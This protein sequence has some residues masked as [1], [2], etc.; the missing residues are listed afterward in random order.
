M[1]RLHG[2]PSIT[3]IHHN[4]LCYDLGVSTKKKEKKVN[5]SALGGSLPRQSC[6]YFELIQGGCNQDSFLRFRGAFQ[7]VTYNN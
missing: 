7:C 5:I 2:L 1:P 4:I 6:I 3:H